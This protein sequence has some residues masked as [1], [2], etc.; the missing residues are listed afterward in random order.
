MLVMIPATSFSQSSKAQW[1]EMKSFHSLMSKSFHPTEENNYAP[2]KEKA[3]S[4]LMAAKAW[5]AS[6]IPADYKPEETRETLDKLVNQCT[7]LAGA[8]K[9]N[10]ADEKLKV[11]ISDA[12]EIFHKIMGECKKGD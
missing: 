2:L 10:A 8:V 9:A 11:L 1:K 12:H 7:V 3:D 4:L 5:Q 6:K